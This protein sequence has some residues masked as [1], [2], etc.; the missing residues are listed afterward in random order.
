MKFQW[1]SILKFYFFIVLTWV[2]KMWVIV[3]SALYMDSLIY[4]FLPRIRVVWLRK[5]HIN[6]N[7]RRR[8]IYEF[9]GWKDKKKLIILIVKETH[10]LIFY[11]EKIKM[12]KRHIHRRSVCVCLQ[13]HEKDHSWWGWFRYVH[14]IDFFCWVLV[15]IFIDISI[16]DEYS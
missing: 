7:G 2:W 3:M 4:W 5:K 10:A 11:Y 16:S 6:E 12:V 14:L 9:E 13:L 8:H 1:G 15:F